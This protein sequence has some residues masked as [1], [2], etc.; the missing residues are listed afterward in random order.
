LLGNKVLDRSNVVVVDV[1]V[2]GVLIE[3][4]SDIILLL[5]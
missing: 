3:L 1:G 4:L 2:G 5:W